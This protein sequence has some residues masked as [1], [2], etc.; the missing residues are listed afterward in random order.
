MLVLLVGT[1]AFFLPHTFLVGFRELISR[2]K[3]KKTDEQN[4][5]EHHPAD[6]IT[7]SEPEDVDDA[8][9]DSE[10]ETED[11]I[12]QVDTEDDERDDDRDDNRKD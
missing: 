11:E 1:L 12:T 7:S 5:I 4:D 3:K 2:L 10:R 6:E 9:R 8:Q